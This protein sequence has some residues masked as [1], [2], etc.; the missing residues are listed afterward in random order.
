MAAPAGLST[1]QRLV[2]QLV[3]DEFRR[4]STWPEFGTLDRQLARRKRGFDLSEV[5]HEVRHSHLIVPWNGGIAPPPNTELKLT[6]CGMAACEGSAD[7]VEL[8]LRTLRWIA[9]QELKYEP[10]PDE[11]EP[12]CIVTGRQLMRAFHLPVARRPDVDR[13]GRLLTVERW[14][15]NTASGSG[16]WDWRFGVGRDVRRF[17]GVAS[18]EDYTARL[19]EWLRQP[20]LT[21]PP[22][23]VMSGVG[24]A[25]TVPAPAAPAPYIDDATLDE[26]KRGLVAA[27]WRP[28]RLFGLLDELNDN[29]T[30][31][32]VYACHMLLRAV[33][34]H[35]PPLFGCK[36]F[37]EVANNRSWGAT[38]ERYVK[39]LVT[40][41][42]QADD[43]LHRHIS[44]RH[45]ALVPSDVPP[46]VWL[47]RVLATAA[48][49]SA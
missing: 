36:R 23:L 43:A 41:R 35:I 39:G 27:G 19:E 38:D 25:A 26:L 3:Y 31:G 14:G 15:W 45:D 32:N 8:F 11:P 6:A 18:I 49:P 46:S 24:Q 40:F 12:G 20:P 10:S 34:D 7:D 30:R 9:R 48:G 1:R 2:V 16:G 33:L 17:A 13:L 44:R 37:S 29:H 21:A 28:E 4:R 47:R 5:A 42:A 22:T